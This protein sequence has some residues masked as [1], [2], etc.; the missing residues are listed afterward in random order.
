MT[1]S[2]ATVNGPRASGFTLLELLVVIGVLSVLTGLSIG[3]LGRTDPMAIAASVLAGETRAA[4]MTS[5]AEG[6]PTEVQLRPGVDNEAATV[7]SRLLQPIVAFHFEPNEGALDESL[8]PTLGGDVVTNG[9]FGAARR[10]RVNE[11]ASVVHWP[12]GPARVELR[13]GFVIRCDVFLEQRAAATI[14]K[15][16]EILEFGVDDEA[17]P[18]ARLRL[19]SGSGETIQAPMA[20]VTPLPLR[21]WCTLD[22]ASDGRFA[23]I[24]HDG[25]EVARTAANG[26]LQQDPDHA[27][28]IAPADRPLPGIVD[29]VRMF[30]YAF[31][32]AQLLPQGLQPRR[33]YTFSFDARGEAVEQ[34]VVEWEGAEGS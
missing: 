8:R 19:H 15:I 3:F 2:A 28:E 5:R 26:S 22:I 14:A 33:A 17:R 9:R 6:V 1:P 20:S 31:A 13:D 11:R 30:V 32:P 18:T 12:L 21:T 4:M 7:Q 29:E 24:S 16:G 34:P 23:W 27:L 10:P 25:R